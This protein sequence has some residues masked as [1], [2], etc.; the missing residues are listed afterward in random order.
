MTLDE[1]REAWRQQDLSDPGELD[2]EELLARVQEKS[3]AFERKIRRRD[4][5]ETLAAVLVAGL[6]SYE[7]VTSATWL[8]R[9]GAVIVVLGSGFIVWWLRRARKVGQGRAADRSVVDWL[10]AERERVE[11]QIH[12]LESVLWWYLAPL[13]VGV[14]LMM[15]ADGWGLWTAGELLLLVIVYGYIWHL[16]QRAVRRCHR[17]R[18]QELARLLRRLEEEPDA[19]SAR[20]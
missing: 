18:R 2:E 14:A 5:L 19:P 3:E 6:F 8:A 4:L 13:G 1:Y 16:N 11:A 20:R 7:A 12:L 9:I 10:R 17:P 15:V